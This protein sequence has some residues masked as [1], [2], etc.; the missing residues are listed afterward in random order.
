MGVLQTLST[1]IVGDS[2]ELTKIP[3]HRPLKQMTE[4]DLIRMESEIGAQIFGPLAPGRRREFFCLDERAWIWY[5]EWTDVM[6]RTQSSTIRYE[7]NETGVL[8]VQDSSRYSYLEGEEYE[9]F[10]LAV[11]I[12]YERVMREIYQRD[13]ATGQFLPAAPMV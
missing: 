6:H 10:A 13:P 5:E 2:S 4:R 3:R 1:L 12:Y 7:I 8:K 11:Q 9:H